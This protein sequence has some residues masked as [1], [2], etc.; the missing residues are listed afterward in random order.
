MTDTLQAEYDKYEKVV[1]EGNVILAKD[2]PRPKE[3]KVVL[4][5]NKYDPHRANLAVFNWEKKAEVEVDTGAVM[6]GRGRAAAATSAPSPPPA[7][8][9]RR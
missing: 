7:A 4:R 8:R 6:P 2:A 1:N 3:N 5:I 9:R